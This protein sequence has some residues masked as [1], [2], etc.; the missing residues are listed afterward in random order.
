MRILFNYLHFYR[1]PFKIIIVSGNLKVLFT[2]QTK[3]FIFAQL[4]FYQEN[5]ITLDPIMRK[6]IFKINVILACICAVLVIISAI[7]VQSTLMIVLAC[8][9]AACAFIITGLYFKLVADKRG[10]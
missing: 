7:K 4:N 5:P 2:F 1:V 8:V 6:W 3:P 9:V 10:N